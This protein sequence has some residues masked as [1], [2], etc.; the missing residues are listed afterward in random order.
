[1]GTYTNAY[2]NFMATVL[3]CYISTLK[4]PTKTQTI[5]LYLLAIEYAVTHTFSITLIV[6]IAAVSTI[7]ILKSKWKHKLY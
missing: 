5:I 3:I 2:E 6:A 7:A 1:M 4:K